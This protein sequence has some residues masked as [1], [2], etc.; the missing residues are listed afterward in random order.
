MYR[1][2]SLQETPV[3]FFDELDKTLL[4]SI[5]KVLE[6]A[7]ANS[8]TSAQLISEWVIRR[9]L[10]SFFQQFPQQDLQQWN[11]NLGMLVDLLLDVN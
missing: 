6:I 2:L 10:H 8:R 1:F 9:G 7:S 5:T 3:L 11:A 4:A